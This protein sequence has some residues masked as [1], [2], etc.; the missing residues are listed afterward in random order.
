MQDTISEIVK[1]L[2]ELHISLR[3]KAMIEQTMF[4]EESK[5]IRRSYDMGNPKI[6][7]IN[8]QCEH[9]KSRISKIS[10]KN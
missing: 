6:S 5:G 7:Q 1:L 4:S 10:N 2:R 9:L 3:D 8:S